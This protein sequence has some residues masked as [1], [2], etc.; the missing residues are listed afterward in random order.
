MIRS[1]SAGEYADQVVRDSWR[2]S[3]SAWPRVRHVAA[4]LTVSLVLMIAGAVSG[5]L[6][7]RHQVAASLTQ[8]PSIDVYAALSDSTP[9]TVTLTIGAAVSDKRLDAFIVELSRTLATQ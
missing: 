3:V 2:T 1:L 8:L 6:W 5:Y 9:I 4:P 7:L